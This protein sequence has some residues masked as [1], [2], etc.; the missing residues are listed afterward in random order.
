MKRACAILGCIILIAVAVGAAALWLRSYQQT[1]TGSWAYDPTTSYFVSSHQGRIEF[2]RQ[3]ALSPQEAA[4]A[5]MKVTGPQDVAT[6]GEFKISG[7]IPARPDAPKIQAGALWFNID[8]HK[9]YT[10]FLGFGWVRAPYLSVLAIPYWFVVLSSLA[11][12]IWLRRRVHLKRHVLGHCSACG[13]DLRA[14]PDR[15]PECGAI[16]SSIPIPR[17]N[18]RRGEEEQSRAHR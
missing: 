10:P 7:I 6:F 1:R 18:D 15:C 8:P 11:A 2:V 12:L 4:Q 16:P 3:K 9:I 5:N 14:T 13:Y 17:Q